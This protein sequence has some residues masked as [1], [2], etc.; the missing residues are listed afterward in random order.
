MSPLLEV[1]GL[2]KH[3]SPRG[4]FGRLNPRAAVHAV[5]GVDLELDR[6]QTLGL[7]GESGCGKSTLARLLVRLEDAT[8]GRV[9]LDG[10]DLL[11]ARGEAL[12]RTR[13]RIQI[14][15]QNPFASLNPRMTAGEII[16]EAWEAHPEIAPKPTWT[17]RTRDLLASVGISPSDE[18][19]YPHELSGGQ[20]QRVGLARALAVEPDVI[21]CD[22]PV[23]SLDVSV[24]AQV[25]NL[26]RDIQRTTGVAYVFIS[27]DLAVVRHVA[28]RIAVMY[29]GKIVETASTDELF[30]RPSHPYTQMLLAAAG[31]RPAP[32]SAA[33][34][35]PS[36]VDPPSGCRFC[37]RCWKAQQVC[38]DEEPALVERPGVPH[39]AACHFAEPSTE[40]PSD[41]ALRPR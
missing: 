33:G 30:T 17:S 22:E 24:Q 14:V 29:L 10:D 8:A 36:A 5:C 27:H 18:Q 19:R 9:T 16:R 25:L 39:P 23:S 37:T 2:V 13:R 40:L 3:F 6:G 1:E 28:D 34:E 15:F 26:L 31:G 11:G 7:V 21:V 41:P 12:R 38:A 35:L 20:R 32:D 4:L